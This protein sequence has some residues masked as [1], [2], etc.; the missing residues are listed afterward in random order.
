[1]FQ[2][3]D[4]VR[5]FSTVAG[6]EKYHLCILVGVDGSAHQFLFLNSDPNYSDTLG[7]DCKRVPCLPPSST[8][9]TAFC[10]TAIPRYSDAQLKLHKAAKL[11]EIDKALAGELYDFA[12]G[13]RA[14]TRP[15][16][17]AVLRALASIRDR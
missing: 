9:V 14:L 13:V 1:M 12:Q 10:F 7:I 17:E 6:K 11:G 5:I 4:I 15:E 16:K 2:V 8:G 3:G